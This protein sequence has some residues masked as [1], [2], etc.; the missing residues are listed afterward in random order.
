MPLFSPDPPPLQPPPPLEQPP[1]QSEP[2]TDEP[3]FKAARRNV[4][5]VRVR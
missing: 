4:V 1:L 5:H 2:E 3:R